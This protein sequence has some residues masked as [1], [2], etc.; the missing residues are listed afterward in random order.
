MMTKRERIKRAIR[1]E[2]VDRVPIAFWRHFP[3]S[4]QTAE[5][6]AEAVLAFQAEYDFDLI[7]VTPTSGYA[8]EDWGFRGTYKGNREGTREERRY[9]V[10]TATDWRRIAPLDVHKGV[11][12]RELAAL[13]RIRAGRKDDAPILETV[14]SPLTVAKNLA[15]DALLPHLRANP[16]ELKSALG[17]IAETT[18][19]FAVAALAAGAE[20]IFFATQFASHDLLSLG[21]YRE[22]GEPYDRVIFQAITGRTDLILLHAHGSRPMFEIVTTY[23]A[24]IL[25]WH[26]RRTPPSLVEG[27]RQFAGAVLGGLDEWGTLGDSRPEQVAI[28]AADAIW[29]TGNRGLILGGG[30]VIPVDTPAANLHAAIAVARGTR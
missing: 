21:E 30:C 15:G 18:A 11:Y 29:Q 10:K 6:L 5:G 16:A 7:K 27:Q 8:A 20:G 3:E 19:Q 26:D 25:N 1:R 23:P 2:A 24:Q 4:D 14:F 22:F 28:Q 17:I 12:G 9:P 13:K